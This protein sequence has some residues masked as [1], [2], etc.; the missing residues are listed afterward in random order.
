M[1]VEHATDVAIIDGSW[2]SFP[3]QIGTAAQNIRAFV[4]T[5]AFSTVTIGAGG[6]EPIEAFGDSCS[7]DRGFLFLPNESLT[8]VPNSIFELGIEINLDLNPAANAGFDTITLGWQGSGGPTVQH[9]TVFNLEL[10]DYWVGI[11]GLNPAPTNFTTFT[12]PQPSFMQQLVNNNTIP[13][14]TYGYTAGNQYRLNGV[15]GSLVLGGYDENRF[16]QTKNISVPFYN[17]VGREQLVNLKSITTDVGSPSNLLPDG[18]IDLLIDSTVAQIW[19]PESACSAFES[20]FGITY[21]SYRE[22]YILN[23]T[24]RSTLQDSNPNVTFTIGSQANDAT[25]DIVLPYSAFDMELRFPPDTNSSAYFP[26]RRAAN[27]TQ[28]TLGRTFLQEA[29]LISDYDNRNFTVAPCTWNS[30]L[31]STTSLKSIIRAN[32]TMS[33]GGGGDSGSNTGAI[34]G[35]VVGGVVGLALIVGAIIWFMRRRKQG[36]KK[37]LAELEAKSAS[38]TGSQDAGGEAKPFIS[39]P[40]GGELGGDGEIHEAYAPHK[41]APQ[42]MD[43][44]YAPDP[45]KHGYSEMGG[46]VGEYFQPAKGVPAEMR[47]STPIYEM[48]GSDVQELPASTH[49]PS[50][51][52]R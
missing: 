2:S 45:N 34:A 50:M 28:Y 37:K 10:Q 5:S 47:G 33:T 22:Y 25:V 12:D 19:L 3:L 17:D 48:H 26:L 21:D 32:E 15:Y 31:V 49:R 9:S 20:A 1:L 23:D 42:E 39:A 41:Q 7:N 52:K 36:E 18:D 13:S 8:W 44:A 35:G 46:G 51:E 27:S 30:S 16:D 24:L 43:S 29:Y 11:F 6:C 38:P 14:L 4:G 40:F